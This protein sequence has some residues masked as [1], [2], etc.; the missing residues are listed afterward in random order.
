MAMPFIWENP[1]INPKSK[2]N[3]DKYR[4]KTYL[5]NDKYSDNGVF[6]KNMTENPILLSMLLSLPFFVKIHIF[7][8]VFIVFKR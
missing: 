6:I 7:R 3:M 4:F 5:M 1:K 2:N 8:E